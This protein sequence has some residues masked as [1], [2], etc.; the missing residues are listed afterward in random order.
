MSP[1]VQ[2]ALRYL[3]AID[4]TLATRVFAQPLNLRHYHFK[5]RAMAPSNQHLTSSQ[6]DKGSRDH[7]VAREP[8]A[9]GSNEWKA[10]APYYIHKPADSFDVKYEASCHCGKVNYQLAQEEPLD[11]KLCH[12]TTCQTQH[13]KLLPFNVHWTTSL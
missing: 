6:E 4:S 7:E 8:T 10:R 3:Q 12:C 9:S 13:G 5:H 2:G 11:S 1:M